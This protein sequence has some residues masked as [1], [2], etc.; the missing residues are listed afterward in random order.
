MFSDNLS[1]SVL[2]LCDTLS[3]SYEAA[4]ERC[5]LSPR[6]FG[7]VARGQTAASIITLEKLYQGFD[8]TPNELLRIL[9]RRPERSFRTAMP[10]IAV[11]CMVIFGSLTGF[12]VC[13]RISVTAAGKSSI[14]RTI[15][16]RPSY[17]PV[18]NVPAHSRPGAFRSQSFCRAFSAPLSSIFFL[19][20]FYLQALI[21]TKSVVL[22]KQK[23]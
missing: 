7:S 9:P 21:M 23:I 16:K 14:G 3:L 18:N 5:N 11:K 17:F 8:R 13:P 22:C 15:A 20:A 2:Q 4:S 1:A 6:Y 19:L 10:V 12:P